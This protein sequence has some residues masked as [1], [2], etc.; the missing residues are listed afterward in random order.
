MEEYGELAARNLSCYHDI[1]IALRSRDF[2]YGTKVITLNYF[3]MQQIFPTSSN[4]FIS[5]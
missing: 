2:K 4:S 5:S 3:I 1:F